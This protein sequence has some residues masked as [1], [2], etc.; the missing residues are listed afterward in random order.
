MEAKTKENLKAGVGVFVAFALVLSIA[1]NVHYFFKYNASIAT[2]LVFTGKIDPNIK[3]QLEEA[4]E[5][6]E[7]KE[8][9]S[10]TSTEALLSD[11]IK[12]AQKK[13][14]PKQVLLLELKEKIE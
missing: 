14:V 8:K 5:V 3:K 2:I 7:H 9:P 11:L 13:G 12:E 6:Q 10:H 4:L 1:Q